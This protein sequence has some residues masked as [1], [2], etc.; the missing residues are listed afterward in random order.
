MVGTVSSLRV[1]HGEQINRRAELEEHIQG[2][3]CATT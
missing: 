1:Q 3:T 2:E